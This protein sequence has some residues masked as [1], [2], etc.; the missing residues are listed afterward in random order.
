MVTLSRL[1]RDTLRVASTQ[2]HGTRQ[3]QQ[4]L[5]QQ[6]MTALCACK[7]PSFLPLESPLN[8]V[9]AGL[10]ETTDFAQQEAQVKDAGFHPTDSH[11]QAH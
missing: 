11:G 7:I 2:Y 8:S 3:T 1:S 10:A 4:C 9:L 5:L 6:A